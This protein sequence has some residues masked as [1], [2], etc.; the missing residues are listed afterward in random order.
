MSEN[1]EKSDS[2]LLKLVYKVLK[3]KNIDSKKDPIVYSQGGPSAPTLTMENFWK[4]YQLRNE[5]DII[6]MDQRGT[7]LS[8]ANCIESGEAAIAILRQ[9][10]TK[11][12]E[13]KALNDLLD[14][15]KE[16]IKHDEVDLSGYNSK[17]IA[18]DFEDLRKELG[19]KK[20]NLFGGSYG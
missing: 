20:W 16:S 1:R 15:C 6:L 12:E 14:E 4:N 10:Y 17:E 5:R 2:R 9:N 19:Y 11:V 3:A 18:A 8:E 13:F 7:G